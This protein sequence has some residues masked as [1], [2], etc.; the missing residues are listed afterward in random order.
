MTHYSRAGKICT[1]TDLLS[2]Q[3]ATLGVK[4]IGL[5]TAQ[6]PDP[7]DSPFSSAT[8]HEIGLIGAICV[9]GCH[10]PWLDTEFVSIILCFGARFFC[11]GEWISYCASC[12]MGISVISK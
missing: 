1:V 6:Q 10:R 9:C 7:P 11:S 2:V 8:E 3:Q 12:H 5:K 4:A